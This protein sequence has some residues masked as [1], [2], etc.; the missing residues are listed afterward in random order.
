MIPS[1]KPVNLNSDLINKGMK[2]MLGVNAASQLKEEMDLFGSSKSLPKEFNFKLLLND[3]KLY[4]NESSSSFRSKGKIGIGFIGQQPI[5]V[6][7]DGNIEIQRRRSGDMIDIYLKADQSTWYYFS[8]FRG[9]MM[10]QSG[11]NSYNS[12]IVKTKLN[13]RKHP[14]SSIKVP[15]TYMIAVEDRLGRFLQRLS[16]IK[17][18]DNSNDLNGLIK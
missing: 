12:I 15:Y 4:W 7:V 14:D 17:V 11:N 1:L 6:Y 8:Y 10:T 2:D 13:D 18:E 9:V 5:N 16:D 3:V